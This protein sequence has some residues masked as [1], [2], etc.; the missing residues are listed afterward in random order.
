M[1]SPSRAAFLFYGRIII[2]YQTGVNYPCNNGQGTGGSIMKTTIRN[3]IT[4]LPYSLHDAVVTEIKCVGDTVILSFAEG[5]FEPFEGDCRRVNGSVEIEGVDWD[6][7]NAYVFNSAKNEGS[8]RG[9]KMTLKAFAAKYKAL[10]FEI[11]NETYG[12]NKS[13]FSGWLWVKGK[14]KECIL[15]LYHAGEMRY[16]TE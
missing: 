3:N 13:T 6:F 2:V 16:V 4:T 9:S 5:Y 15:E 8:F 10:R 7:C 11:I 14:L 1:E 12:Y